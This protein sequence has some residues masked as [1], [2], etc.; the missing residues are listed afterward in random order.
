V[1]TG[2]IAVLPEPDSPT[3][4]GFAGGD[5]DADLVHRLVARFAKA[6]RENHGKVPH[7]QQ[8]FRLPLHR[9]RCLWGLPGRR[10]ASSIR[11]AGAASA[12]ASMGPTSALTISRIVGRVE[13]GSSCIVG[14]GVISARV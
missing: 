11:R 1:T 10:G 3:P 13:P 2:E 12:S 9:L 14:T 5:V 4:E 6:T 8:R 7:R